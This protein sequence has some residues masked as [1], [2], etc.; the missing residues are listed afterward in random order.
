MRV[1]HRYDLPATG[2]EQPICDMAPRSGIEDNRPTRAF[3]QPKVRRKS[4]DVVG[5]R[6]AD[7]AGNDC[8]R[9]LLARG[10]HCSRNEEHHER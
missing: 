5:S 2:A 8:E 7:T 4:I 6:N 3:D 10:M 9:Q 1:D